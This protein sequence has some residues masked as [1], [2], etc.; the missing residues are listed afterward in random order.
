MRQFY[1]FFSISIT[2]FF[3]NP[4]IAQQD[5]FSRSDSGT[6]LWRDDFNN[7]WFYQNDN[8]NQNRP[9]NP[10][11]TR[12]FVKIGHNANNPMTTNGAFFQLA[13]LDL[14]S[15]ADQARTFNNDG[16]GISLTIGI[17]NASSATHTFNTPIGVDGTTV[18][19]HANFS[20][21][22]TFNETIFINNNTVQF[23]N[24]GTGEILV[25]GTLQGTGNVEKVGGN[26]LTISGNNTYTGTTTVSEGTLVLQSDLADSDV[27][28]QSGAT[29]EIDGNVTVKSL[30]VNGGGT[31]TINAGQ[32]LTVTG[33]FNNS[34]TVTLNSTSTQYASLIVEGTATG[35]VTYNRYVNEI[36]TTN[37]NNAGNDLIA[38]PVNIADFSVFAAANSNLATS[39]NIAAFA[40]WDP[41]GTG[42]YNNL[43]TTDMNGLDLGTGY[44]AATT[45]GS[46]LSFTGTVSTSPVDKTITDGSNSFWNLI[47]NPYP[48][49][50]DFGAF[51]TANS[52]KLRPGFNA[53]YGYNGDDSALPNSLWTTWDNNQS[54]ELLAPGQGFFVASPTTG[55]TINFT[56]AMQVTGSSNDF[57]AGRNAANNSNFAHAILNLNTASSTFVTNLYFRD[58]NTLGLDPGYDTGAFVQNANGIYTHLVEGNEGIDLF[59]QSLPYANLTDVVVPLVVNLNP[60]EQITFSL[61]SGS[62]LPESI[63]VLLEDT[64]ENTFTLLNS[65][66]YT[67]TPSTVLSGSGRFFLRFAENALSTA[68]NELDT[69]FIFA[70]ANK[71]IVISGLLDTTS[72]AQVYD[73]QGRM[74]MSQT[75]D[76]NVSPQSINASALTSGVYIVEVS[77]GTL[78]KIQKL[79]LR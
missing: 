53:V 10:S 65:G 48:S 62:V 39:A 12:N 57:I 73:L 27:T 69:L 2:L 22:M 3:I 64:V 46:P 37:T 54:S 68:E 26:T 15:S 18:Q 61:N 75:L 33:D 79:I 9:D 60:N 77:N 66:D 8:N 78:S 49:Y 41:N 7:P 24:L 23:G 44:R 20:G 56:T 16:G 74:V 34:G 38:P 32:G 50:L 58:I 55:E 76:P 59:N 63:D 43:L 28:V 47:G 36:G 71:Q 42:T 6:G 52:S 45:D 72:T 29:L 30:T 21:G 17:F 40:T 13:S 14:Q 1:L 11:S 25:T 4:V 31:V 35:N 5:V 51:F 67:I 70:N 19:I